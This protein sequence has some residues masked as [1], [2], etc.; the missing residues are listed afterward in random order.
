MK[1]DEKKFK[2]GVVWGLIDHL[3][4]LEIASFDRAHSKTIE[5][6]LAFRSNY[7]PMFPYLRHSEILI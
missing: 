7:V 4:S 5:V 1:Y 3:R 2:H 6:P